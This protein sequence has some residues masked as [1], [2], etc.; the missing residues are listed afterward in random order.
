LH[1]GT[2]QDPRTI[3]LSFTV[4]PNFPTETTLLRLL[5]ALR[6]GNPTPRVLVAELT[7]GPNTGVQVECLVTAGQWRESLTNGM[8]VDF[9][10]ADG[11]WQR[12]EETVL[13]ALFVANGDVVP[14]D[15][16]GG[17]DV[18]PE[19]ILGWDT[20]RVSVT[21]D[22]GWKYVKSET[23]RNS[24]TRPWRKV[25]MTVDLGDTA[26][27]VSAGKLQADG[28]DLR[29]RIHGTPPWMEIPRTLTNVNTKRTFC[30]FYVTIPAG[31]SVQYDFCYGNSAATRPETLSVRTENAEIYAADDLGGD[32]GAAS[33]GAANTLTDSSKAW[34]SNRWRYG[35]IQIV[36]G[37]GAGQRRK[38]TD[39][40]GT[41][42]TVGRNWSTQPNA[43]SV[44]VIWMTGI[45]VSGGIVT[46]GGTPTSL[47]DSSQAWGTDEFKGGYVY[48]IT[49]E[50]GPYR[51]TGNT[52]TA[53]TTETMSSAPATSDS[54]YIEKYGVLNYMVNRSVT[55]TDHRG[56]WRL[57][58]YF[59]K[60]GKVWYG[61]QTPGGWLPWLMLPNNDDFALGR[62]VDEGSGGGHAINNWPYLY[63]RRGVRSDNTWPEKGQ[64][65]GAAL[66]DPRGFLAIDF[67]Y[68]M[69]NEGA[70]T[71]IGQVVL[72][73]Q[74]PNG[75]AW[76]TVGSDSTLRTSLVN[77]T[78]G[79]G[80]AGYNT[81]ASDGS[82]V[83]I[84]LGVLP[85]DGVEIAS[86]VKKARSVELRNHAK[87]VVHLDVT[88]CGSM[89][90]GIYVVGSETE[91]Y[92]LQATV[93]LGGGDDAVPPYDVLEAA[94]LLPDGQDM[95]VNPSLA[96]GLPLLGIYETSTGELVERAALG[97]RIV[98]Y[99]RGIDGEAVGTESK[100]L[101][102]LPPSRNLVPHPD[103]V[104]GWTLNAAVG[105]T[106]TL[107]DETGAYYG[108][109]AQAIRINIAGSPVG[110]WSLA[111]EMDPI[112]LTVLPGTLYEFGAIVRSSITGIDVS[113]NAEWQ[114]D[115]PG[116]ATS[117]VDGIDS[118]AVTILS[119]A[120][121]YPLGGG[122]KT[123]AGS[124]ITAPTG[125]VY[126]YLLIEGTGN[127]SGNIYVD[128][129]TLGSNG[130]I[131]LYVTEE[132]P[133]GLT[134]A[135]T[136]TEAFHG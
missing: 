104:A 117:V 36:A 111:L 97:A 13:P 57:S 1:V 29:V 91:V 45:H 112:S 39:N 60:G 108:P 26:A 12:R 103:D 127:V 5:A 41:V 94:V 30:H 130:P 136:W 63:P 10:A 102:P 98:H 124:G 90:N 92:D 68:R 20:Q 56:L 122:R 28:D 55:E 126:L 134:F 43:T 6:C 14:L 17:A 15:N 129:V 74:D 34:E 38:I 25:R 3:T 62:Y 77:V 131:N 24:G 95:R 73:S 85:A 123:H 65:D 19:L 86:N 40:T 16:Q 46:T 2:R 83:R 67:D 75:D 93:R 116:G 22:V 78:S 101:L 113:I 133:G 121:W 70:S 50:I 106:A 120:R 119:S 125:G 96:S 18:L 76:Q 109:N 114:E 99:E 58:R 4:K 35:Y 21:A 8:F 11:T 87:M 48:N 64:H 23:I 71:G 69:K 88:D 132:E 44:Y 59:Q 51:I 7:D 135:A 37:T 49:K 33:A 32:S 9:T 31:Q 118:D 80:I 105:V 66:F 81:L 110:A 42:I 107:H 52:A 89:T 100:L 82:P 47:T 61:D 115:G 53:L 72:M 79:S 128:P 84:Y 54:Y 27:L